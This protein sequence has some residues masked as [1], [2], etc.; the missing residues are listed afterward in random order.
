MDLSPFVFEATAQDFEPLVAGNSRQGPVLVYFWAPGAGSC[1]ALTPRLVRLATEYAG[2]FL[3]VMVNT[4]H[5]GR[6]ARDFGVTSRPTL[7]LFV[8]GRSIETLQRV[9]TDAELR[10]LIDAHLVRPS[11]HQHAQAVAAFEAGDPEHA[12]ALLTRAGTAD[13]ANLRIPVDHAKLLIRAGRIEEAESLLAALP[14]DIQ[15]RGEVE[16]LRAHTGFLLAAVDAPDDAALLEAIGQ[17]ADDLESR[18]RLAARRVVADDVEGALDELVEIVAR[19][20]DYRADAARR[21]I[22]AVFAM[23]GDDSPVVDR[24]RA[25]LRTAMRSHH[26]EG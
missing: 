3:L 11:D 4:D 17:D 15:E 23:L 18:Y 12:F 9:P 7:K 14:D 8:G 13:P 5:L 25:R 22:F 1:L 21:G 6:I 16:Q 2:R 10:A 19:D 20:T 24:Y 26:R